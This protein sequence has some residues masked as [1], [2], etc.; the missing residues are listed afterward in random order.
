MKPHQDQPSLDGALVVVVQTEPLLVEAIRLHS[1]GDV[2]Q[3][4][5]GLADTFIFH[6]VFIH[7]LRCRGSI[8]RVIKV[9]TVI[10]TLASAE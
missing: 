1:R 7:N 10:V 3:R 8:I 9:T 4:D 2:S 6:I 5:G